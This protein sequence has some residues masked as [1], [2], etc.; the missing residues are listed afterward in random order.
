MRLGIPR[1]PRK[2]FGSRS[3]RDRPP[4]VSSLSARDLGTWTK[5]EKLEL[6][7]TTS[8]ALKRG[9]SL[10][11]TIDMALLFMGL[12]RTKP[13]M[14]EAELALTGGYQHRFFLAERK[15]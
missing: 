13:L 9:L 7:I 8:P 2:I 15:R 6:P 5:F 10:L 11:M 4:A 1:A 14:Y 12:P 3:R